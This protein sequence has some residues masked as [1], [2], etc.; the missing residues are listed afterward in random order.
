MTGD[1][2]YGRLGAILVDRVADLYPDFEL[3]P[4]RYQITTTEG[5]APSGKIVDYVWESGQA[6][7]YSEGYDVFYDLY[8]DP[9]VVNFLS[10]KAAKYKLNTPKTTPGMIRE[11]IETGILREAFSAVRK[12]DINGNFGTQHQVVALAG[13]VLDTFPETKEMI[14]WCFQPGTGAGV[15]MVRNV[16]GG[17]IDNWITNKVDRD[18]HTRE[19]APNYSNMWAAALA[20]VAEILS[21]YEAYSA[22]DMFKNPKYVKC[23]YANMPLILCKRM[24]AAIGDSGSCASTAAGELYLNEATLPLAFQSTGL[25]IFAQM[26]YFI[27]G[28]K[29]DGLHYNMYTKDP[30]R[31]A[32][33][34]QKVIDEQGEYD[35]YSS[36]MLPHY[37]F[38][39]LRS[40][41]DYSTTLTDS[42]YNSMRDFWMKFGKC[43]S[44]G[45]ADALNLGVDAFGLDLAPE[46]GYPI[47][48]IGDECVNWGQNTISHNT[49]VVDKERS[50]NS[51][52]HGTPR[53]F[54]DGGRVKVMDANADEAYTTGVSTYRRTVVMVE[55]SD[56]ESY[57]VDFFHVV[58]GQEHMYSF[59]AL[60][61]SLTEAPEGLTMVSQT[62]ASGEYVGTYAGADVPYKT[63]GISSGYSYLYNV[64]RALNPGTGEFAVDFK[65]RDFRKTLP[66]DK[67]LHLRMNMLNEKP[68]QEVVVCNGEPAQKLD[69]PDT[70]K[71]MLVRNNGPESLF[72]AVI[73][74]YSGERYLEACEQLPRTQISKADG[75]ALGEKEIVRALKMTFKSGRVDYVLYAQDTSTAYL[76]SDG[77]LEIPF[78]G[79]VG[80]YTVDASGEPIYSYLND[81]VRLGE[82]TAR[83]AYTGSVTDF[84]R[85]L[86]FENF[87]TVQFDDA[88]AV[89]VEELIGRYAYI[90]G[91]GYPIKEVTAQADG[92]VQLHLGDT[93]LISERFDDGSYSYFLEN[94][95]RVR[96]PLSAKQD[97]APVFNP[98][99]ENYRAT[100]GHS[101]QLQVSAVSP[102]DKELS[103]Q[104]ASLPRGASFDP[105]TGTISWT[106]DANQIGKHHIAITVT[107]GEL[108]TTIHF[109]VTVSKASSGNSSSES[110]TPP[111][112]VDPP[113]V[114]PPVVDPPEADP[115]EDE[116]FIDLGGYDWAKD[117][118]NRLAEAGII[119]GTGPKTYSP[120]NPITRADFAILLTRALELPAA[121]S[122]D[123]FVDVP[124]G[125][126]YAAELLAAKEAGIVKGIGENRFNPS[127]SISREDMMLMLARAMDAAGRELQAADTSALAAF[128]DSAQVADYAKDAVSRLVAAGVIAG[129][130]GKINPKGTAT[131]AEV[132][133]MLGR[134][135]LD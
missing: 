59:H 79:F 94:G 126:Y 106:P 24:T 102:V 9:Q 57:G 61:D 74:P 42:S 110:V 128:A 76:I 51:G 119:Q 115:P 13:V 86:E 1:K 16:T 107:D 43:G 116:R 132:A 45:H 131:R 92:T 81:G 31:L 27:N 6:I 135:F 93:S 34:V 8:D 122:G 78:Q 99:E 80:V 83:D 125:A 71:Y 114:D 20:N 130:N 56:E 113:V 32:S 39:I 118:I 121:S 26:M 108:E 133:V 89:N 52:E 97:T 38:A 40:G 19:G 77:E 90:E 54:D 67:D 2:R 14:D 50:K 29:S 62:N 127:G 124:Q 87:I 117:S 23:I 30:T 7:G 63:E 65:I 134:I 4:Y 103:Y 12:G 48:S 95:D 55:A 129:D 111:S 123:N 98:M 70:L 41:K 91:E 25:P 22:K 68:V 72:T 105:E 112:V 69:N 49:V 73:E 84:T 66:V 10:K 11:N 64:D 21:G 36:D 47:T 35:F 33:D 3:A 85:T 101:F 44:H 96:I 28:D 18:G 109:M 100:A 17:N 75:S 15:W 5:Y 88:A 53:H 120:G 37:N 58:G 82:L 104:A 60:S 46:L